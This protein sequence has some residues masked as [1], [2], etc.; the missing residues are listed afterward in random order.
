MSLRRL[1]DYSGR[2]LGVEQ[3]TLRRPSLAGMKSL[4]PPKIRGFHHPFPG[5]ALVSGAVV[6]V[7][8][9]PANELGIGV[10]DNQIRQLTGRYR[11][12]IFQAHQPG[13][14]AR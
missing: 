11:A 10:E 4:N 9:I 1:S 6:P 8:K 5:P 13:R 12:L 7:E 2:L 3:P 14:C